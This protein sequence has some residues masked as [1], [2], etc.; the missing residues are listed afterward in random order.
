[1]RIGQVGEQ[2]NIIIEMKIRKK[3]IKMPCKRKHKYKTN[4]ARVVFSSS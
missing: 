1:M 2:E 3:Q 4:N